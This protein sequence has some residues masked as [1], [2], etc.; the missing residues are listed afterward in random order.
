MLNLKLSMTKDMIYQITLYVRDKIPG[1]S[2][3]FTNLLGVEPEENYK[4]I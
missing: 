4:K 1:G 2:E 3:R